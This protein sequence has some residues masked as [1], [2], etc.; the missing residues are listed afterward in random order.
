MADKLRLPS[1]DEIDFE[2][3]EKPETDIEK[4]DSSRLKKK[5][6]STEKEFVKLRIEL[7][8]LKEKE[9]SDE[10]T[11]HNY[12]FLK[13]KLS[14]YE[15]KLGD[16]LDAIEELKEGVNKA[17][18][19]KNKVDK[20]SDFYKRRYIE[21]ETKA[22]NSSDLINQAN[23]KVKETENKRQ[24]LLDR[25]GFL[26]QEN[27]RVLG[28]NQALKSEIEKNNLFIEN[29]Q[30]RI[31]TITKKSMETVAA[32]DKL[33]EKYSS[34]EKINQ[35]LL[36]NEEML[37]QNLLKLKQ[38]NKRLNE[39]FL[40]KQEENAQKTNNL[41]KEYE[42][43]FKNYSSLDNFKIPP[44]LD[45]KIQDYEEKLQRSLD[46]L[47]TL[48]SRI[49][50][51]TNI[52]DKLEKKTEYYKNSYAELEENKGKHV[53]FNEELN[54]KI[55]ELEKQNYL[56][57]QKNQELENKASFININHQKLSSELDKRQSSFSESQ[58]K[59]KEVSKKSIVTFNE[60]QV[61]K[62]KYESSLERNKELLKKAALLDYALAKLKEEHM[63][64]FS[65]LKRDKQ[66]SKEEAEA[67]KQN[68]EERIR[69]IIQEN[70][71]S[72]VDLRTENN[73]LNERIEQLNKLIEDRNSQTRQFLSTVN[74]QF[75][76]FSNQD[77]VSM[78]RRDNDL[79]SMIKMG[80][81]HKDS[82]DSIEKSLMNYGYTKKEINDAL[83]KTNRRSS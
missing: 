5:L 62:E 32:L 13:K 36:L 83:K 27:L 24:I 55:K 53:A 22:G 45:K 57:S 50:A 79:I 38:E 2:V 74:T 4:T 58:E 43:R 72:I 65:E 30:K 18:D 17:T 75:G 12:T 40:E 8:H 28:E 77:Q 68:Y 9:L 29:E 14:D 20:K 48:R 31:N 69:N 10:Y 41:K 71:T 63:K 15:L 47:Q 60:L 67:L 70:T 23:Q 54:K 42:S 56:L 39:K 37:R 46:E 82:I 44:K 3:L 49:T 35:T 52:K 76:F 51:L 66:A 61:F 19:I 59:I 80:L 25:L 6:D 73:I 81:Q 21:I 64:L 34:L 26:E 7:A 11:P 78:K 33:D 1:V 16:I